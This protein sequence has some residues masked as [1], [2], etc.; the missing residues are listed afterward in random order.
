MT[1]TLL[2][3]RNL[4]KFFPVY[5]GLF[6][7]QTA[8]IKAV[9]GI[10]FKVETGK[11]LGMVGESGSGKSTAGRAAI[12]LIEPTEGHISFL[13]QDL[14]AMSHSELKSVR[15]NVQMIFQNP[16]SS[17]NPR[18]TIG[19]AIG[20]GLIYHGLVKTRE[21][22][23]ETV[24]ETLESVGLSP[25]A[26]RK[27]PH[28]FSGGQQQR[29]CIGRAIAMRPQLIICDEAVSAL[30]VSIQAQVLNLLTDLKNKMGF[31]YLFI[32]HD[33][34]VIE[35]ICDEVVVLYLGKVMECASKQELFRNPKH[36]YTQAL[37]SAIPRSYPG[38]EKKRILLKGEIPSA[39]NPPSGC[40][41]RTRCPY[42]QPI[43]AVTPPKK[44]VLDL[45][46]GKKDHIYHC[47]LD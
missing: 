34:S 25:D 29:I 9:N 41:F 6:R 21:E 32:S 33:L 18:K 40:P 15:K 27:Y 46:S 42:A 17:L 10:D 47:I 35:H 2:E 26:M 1:K 20:E 14:L 45:V 16:Y 5:S 43:C 7:H 44:E 19:E 30:D 28:Q 3:V 36:P 22:Q 12:R 38:Q 23:I 8:E 4:K 39:Q 24:A 13:G 31:S 11:V 37:L